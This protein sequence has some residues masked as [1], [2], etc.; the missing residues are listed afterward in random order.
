MKKKKKKVNKKK[1]LS[2][3]FFL[4]ILIILI[5]IVIKSIGKKAVPKFDVTVIVNNEDITNLLNDT[6]YMNKDNILYLSINDVKKIFDPNIYYEN[7]KIIT[8]SGTKVAAI[9]VSNNILELNSANLTLSVGVLDYGENPYIPVSEMSN[10]YNIEAFTTEKSTI[11]TSLYEEFVTIKTMKK[12]S[13][14]EKASGFSKTIK[15]VSDGTELI[16]IGDSEK[17]GWIKV[18]T[19]ERRYSD[20]SRIKIYQKRNIK[21]LR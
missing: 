4:F 17:K 21:G 7:K 11:I 5:I 13:I 6:P 2:R 1:F 9:D 20:I 3:I 15:K 19:F 12:T 14:K 18:L 16:Y 10:V 8:T